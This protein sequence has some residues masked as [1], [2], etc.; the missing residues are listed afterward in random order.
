MKTIPEVIKSA[1]KIVIKLGS[2]TISGE[3]GE[4][5]YE[6]M[7]NI[8]SQVMGLISLGKQVALV[9]SGAQICGIAAINKWKRKNDMNFKQAL[10]AIG[11]VEL[12]NAY[13]KL[14]WEYSTHVGQILLTREDFETHHRNLGIRNT[15]FTLIDEGV[16]P[17]INENDT[18][19]VEEIQIGDN[20]SL[21]ALTANLWGADLL[22]I[23]SDVEG[24]YDK[25]PKTNPDAKLIE[26]VE[27]VQEIIGKVDTSGKND[28]GT[29]GMDTK[30]IAARMVSQYD[31]SM[32]VTL[33][34]EKDIIFKLMNGEKQAT[35]FGG[36]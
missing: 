25:N 3:D 10:C 11:Q 5:N 23:M 7:E 31:I 36:K 26:Y 20:D 9:S 18:V 32:I 17:I 35:L 16:V 2:N 12:M 27:D 15:L 22:I 19:C 28:F 6:R 24:L 33:G 29:G 1:R 13:K 30:L 14:F 4:F 34:S 21:S 8:V